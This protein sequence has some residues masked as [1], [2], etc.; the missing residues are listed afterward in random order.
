MYRF[1]EIGQNG[2]FRAKMAIFFGGG[3]FA[4]FGWKR[5]FFFGKTENVTFLRLLSC[6]FVEKSNERIVRS[7]TDIRTYERTDESDFIG[8]ISAPRGTKN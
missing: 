8:P 3:V 5:D 4:R 6:R 2:R 1:G 7:R